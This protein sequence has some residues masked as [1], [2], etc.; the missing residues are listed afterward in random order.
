[1]AERRPAHETL[2]HAFA[3]NA[4]LYNRIP[5]MP[6]RTE[7][8]VIVALFKVTEFPAH[9]LPQLLSSVRGVKKTMLDCRTEKTNRPVVAYLRQELDQLVENVIADLEA[10]LAT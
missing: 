5:S 10:R 3:E 6:R 9:C 1:M 7:L 4:L 8:C 2:F